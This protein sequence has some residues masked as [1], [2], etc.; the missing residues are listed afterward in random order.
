MV[1]AIPDRERVSMQPRVVWPDLGRAPR[2]TLIPA[3]DPTVAL[4]SCY[5]ARARDLVDAQALTALLNSAIAAAWL[6]ILAEPAR[7]G[8]RRYMGWT[9]GLLP[10]PQPWERARSVMA[11]LAAAALAGSR[12]TDAR[13]TETVAAAYGLDLDARRPLLSWSGA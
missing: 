9:V 10:L 2:A 7:G 11:P 6:N 4:N 5:I 3:G 8:Y 13:L 12:P 1:G